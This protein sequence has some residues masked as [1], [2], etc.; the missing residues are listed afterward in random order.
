[1]NNPRSDP[2]PK[3]EKIMILEW[4]TLSAGETN[5]RSHQGRYRIH[6]REKARIYELYHSEYIT[7]CL[8]TKSLMA[9]QQI[10]QILETDNTS[11]MQGEKYKEH[12]AESHLGAIENS[13]T[14]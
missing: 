7:G 5:S 2:K 12:I 9:G 13:H 4:S 11:I 14:L 3:R 1:M 8:K 10:A 6:C